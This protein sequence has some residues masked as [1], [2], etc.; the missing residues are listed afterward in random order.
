MVKL[1]YSLKKI[2]RIIRLLDINAYYFFQDNEMNLI[3][4]SDYSD[5]DEDSDEDSSDDCEENNENSLEIDPRLQ[6]SK[7]E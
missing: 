4:D 5:S 2:I 1:K 3:W 7:I 6:H